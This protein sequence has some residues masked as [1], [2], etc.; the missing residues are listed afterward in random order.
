MIF[1]EQLDTLAET[2]IFY[3]WPE[4]N[5]ATHL[6]EQFPLLELWKGHAPPTGWYA[7]LGRTSPSTKTYGQNFIDCLG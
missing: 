1:D 6:M 3:Y 4:S 7:A 5:A 2:L